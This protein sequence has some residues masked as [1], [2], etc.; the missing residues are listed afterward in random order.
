VLVAGEDIS[1]TSAATPDAGQIPLPASAEAATGEAAAAPAAPK[2]SSE[3]VGQVP[4]TAA[5]EADQAEA[6]AEGRR[7]GGSGGDQ[8]PPQQAAPPE[9]Q[10]KVS[11]ATAGEATAQASESSTPAQSQSA[12]SQAAVQPTPAA[13]PNGAP[14]GTAVPAQAPANSASNS[15]SFATPQ[16]AAPSPATAL[17]ATVRLAAENG[18]SRA[19]VALRP[20]E[21][22]GVELFLRNGSAGITATVVAETPQAAHLLQHGAGELQRRLAAQGIELGSIQ[23]SVGGESAGA[24]QGGRDQAG[25]ASPRAGGSRTDGSGEGLLAE[26]EQTQTIDLGGGVLVDVLA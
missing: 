21:L 23:I 24:A 5:V 9:P 13:V 25:E 2:V 8:A 18:Y 11:D 3:T 26:P 16:G 4:T 1:A 7:Q 22:G 14:V 10:G 19:R 15:L 6:P 20:A 17:E 12:P